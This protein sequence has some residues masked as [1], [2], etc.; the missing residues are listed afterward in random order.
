[1]STRLLVKVY[2]SVE[3]V[4]TMKYDQTYLQFTQA[5]GSSSIMTACVGSADSISPFYGN[6]LHMQ[7]SWRNMDMLAAYCRSTIGEYP[8]FYT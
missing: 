7:L 8:Y 1:M 6:F 3:V 5:A 2:A 4:L